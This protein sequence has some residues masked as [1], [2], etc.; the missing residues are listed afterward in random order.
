[1]HLEIQIVFLKLN[2]QVFMLLCV[3]NHYYEPNTINFRYKTDV[4]FYST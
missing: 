4:T 2:F 1:M 3:T